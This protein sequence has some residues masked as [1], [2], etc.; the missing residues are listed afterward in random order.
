MRIRAYLFALMALSMIVSLSMSAP[1]VGADS[2]GLMVDQNV[3][4]LGEAIGMSISYMSGVHGDMKLSLEDASG[5]VIYEWTWD[6]ANSDPFQQS[7]SYVPANAGMYT[8]RVM[9]EPH[10]MEPPASAS[11][12]VAVWSAKIRG[13]EYAGTID[14]GKPV[15]VKAM[16]DYYFTQ[17]TQMKLSLWSNTEKREMATVTQSM[18]GQGSAT[19]TMTGVVF[20]KAESQDLTASIAYMSP[21]GGWIADTQGST[22]SSNASVVPEFTVTP[23]LMLLTSLLSLGVLTRRLTRKHAT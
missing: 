23:A 8:I 16:V 7:V 18:N 22:Y 11:T 21:S 20:T 9:H 17:P 13:L 12:Q 10:H 4:A 1:T 14:A 15:D 6:H 5:N 3:H 19:L 2:V